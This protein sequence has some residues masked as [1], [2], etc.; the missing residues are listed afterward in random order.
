MWSQPQQALLIDS[1]LRGFDIPKIFLRKRRD[2]SSHLFDVID[3]KQRLTAI[4]A[5]FANDLPLLRSEPFPELG[6]LSGKHWSDLSSDA[7]DRLQFST[8][9]ISTIQQATDDE[10]RELF[11]RLQDG[12]P[13]NAAERRN[14]MTG[15]VRDF[16]ADSM[17]KHDLW[18][19]TRI[20]SG[21]FGWHE[22]SAIVL[23]LIVA[24]GP[25]GLKGADLLK[26][27]SNEKF[28]PEGA[29]ADRAI[30]LLDG[31]HEATEAGPGFIRTRWG[32]VDL[33]LVLMRLTAER[34]SVPPWEAMQ[35][36]KD[37]EARRRSVA[38]TLIELQ[39][40]AVTGI[41]DR[42]AW[43]AEPDA[44]D[45]I[46]SDELTY[47]LAFAREGASKENV[48]KRHAVM[49]RKFLEFL[50]G[51]RGLVGLMK[52]ADIVFG[53][54]MA[55]AATMAIPIVGFRD[56]IGWREITIGGLCLLVILH[57]VASYVRE[58]RVGYRLGRNYMRVWRR[59]LD[60]VV[61]LSHFT[62]ENPRPWIVELYLPRYERTLRWRWPFVVKR[63]LWRE[64][65]VSLGIPLASRP[66]IDGEHELFG[67]CFAKGNSVLWWDSRFVSMDL[68]CDNHFDRLTADTNA[69]LQEMFGMVAVW[70]LVDKMGRGC[71]GLLII[72]TS[73]D[74][75]MTTTVLGAFRRK[76]TRFGVGN[77]ASD[78]YE[79]ILR[80]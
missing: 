45:P 3:G 43:A 75:E 56:E 27:Y 68:D 32:L 21:R 44:A 60:L 13:L 74:A 6:D 65:P 7:R 17:A 47:H 14:A 9:T 59:T 78:I 8:I 23:A 33:A 73:R 31:L 53:R 77:A 71:M 76:R 51:E 72:H 22:H 61:E 57:S 37:F 46:T 70:P 67:E 41:L 52:W 19:N 58:Q 64:L 66:V 11:L 36:F 35:F 5:Y 18:R 62:A 54:P 69:E 28:D 40:R 63:T 39:T 29:D 26:L 55:V 49:Y 50:D 12:E 48:E 16:V 42:E 10:I 79:H 2:G 38:E 20:R 15:P 25:V 1:I 80:R 30:R 34:T 4:W 24:G